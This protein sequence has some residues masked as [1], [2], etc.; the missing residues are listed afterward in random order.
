MNIQDVIKNVADILS[1]DDGGDVTP[2]IQ[3]KLLRGLDRVFDRFSIDSRKIPTICQVEHT[4]KSCDTRLSIGK[5]K[6]FSLWSSPQTIYYAAWSHKRDSLSCCND[7]RHGYG[8]YCDEPINVI[9]ND[10]DFHRGYTCKDIDVGRPTTI[11]Y[12]RGEIV[13]STRP[14]VGDTLILRAKMPF[15]VQIS[16]CDNACK[17][18]V[19]WEFDICPS[20]VFDYAT[21]ESILKEAREKFDGCDDWCLKTKAK[22]CGD[23][24]SPPVDVVV[25]AR[26]SGVDCE[27]EVSND[28]DLPDGY[29]YALT[30]IL[31]YEL[32]IDAKVSD[33]Q[34]IDQLKENRNEAI[35]L[36]HRSNNDPFPIEQDHTTP[37]SARHRCDDDCNTNYGAVTRIGGGC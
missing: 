20:H 2:E 29:G 25:T 32:R 36:L 24:C 23:E 34:R 12:Q 37:W 17:K 4:I 31:A 27:S 28:G 21:R 1:W 18:P 7:K 14:H 35:K 15:N 13:F 16:Q 9:C 11:Y 22:T 6:Q 3:L 8:G 26:R 5:N 33:P 30:H 19:D 10:G